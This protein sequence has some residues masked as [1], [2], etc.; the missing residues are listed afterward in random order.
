MLASSGNLRPVEPNLQGSQPI[1][2]WFQKKN[3]QVFD[4][5]KEA[6]QRYLDGFSGLIHAS[7]GTGKTYAIWPAPLIEWM[8]LGDL[9]GMIVSKK[10][11]RGH[12]PLTVLW[13]T[14]LR[15]L[16][17][18]IALS[19]LEPV[20]DLDLPFTVETR[21]GD[22][23]S[24]RR[25]KQRE[26]LPSA[27]VTTP[28]SLSILLSYEN[29]AESFK[30]LKLVVV[31]EWHELIGS[32]R[33]VQVEL[34]L[35]RLRKLAPDLRI[36]GLSATI[37]NLEQALD[38]LLGDHETAKS[39]LVQA[40]INKEVVA[41]SV[42]PTN[43]DNLPWTGH[44]G[45]PMVEEV[46]KLIDGGRTSIVFT[47]VRSQTEQ[48][49]QRI[50]EAREDF[51]GVAALHHGSL[52]ADVRRWV[53]LALKEER[54][55]FVVSTSSLDLGVDFSPVDRVVQIGSPKGVARAMQRAG[56]SGHS[57]GLVSKLYLVPSHALE[58]VEM[59]AARIAMSKGNVECR[60]PLC[61]SIDV[62]CQHVVTIALGTGFEPEDLYE[63]VRSTHAFRNLA[64]EDWSWI[65]NFAATGGAALKAYPEHQRI[66]KEG[67][68]YVISD[69][70]LALKHRL[71][72][73]TI[74]SD[75]SIEVCFTS[76]ER[77]GQVEESF[78]SR[79]K[80]GDR[81]IFAGRYLELV[82]VRGMKARVRIS[83]V[84]SG[85]IPRWMGGR[86]PLSSEL[87][88]EVRLLISK[89]SVG[90]YDDV[91]M[92]FLR[93]LLE[94]QANRS[95]LPE[96]GQILVETYKSRDGYHLF[97]YPF[98]GRLVNEGIAILMAYQ[99][100]RISPSTYS[101]AMN[102]WG[103]EILSDRP[104]LF[105]DQGDEKNP[106][107]ASH[108][109]KNFRYDNLADDIRA[110]LNSTEMAKRQFREIARV[111]GLIFQGYPGANKTVKQVQVSSGLLYDV[112]VDFDPGNLLVRQAH[113]EVLERHLE[114]SRMIGALS[115]L[116][117]SEIVE[118]SL[119]KAS[120]FCLPLMVDRLRGKLTS[121]KLAQRILR[122]QLDLAKDM[123][124]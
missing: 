17:N 22:T 113:D 40:N 12:L 115:R 54:L 65:L 84:K 117:S 79:L 96:L 122:M 42:L 34:A 49:Y 110:C 103:F 38:C 37:G 39:C 73:G 14:P 70:T 56:R 83:P 119:T 57:P 41:Q 95:S 97:V 100:S 8:A 64:R 33:G 18:D 7:T 6:W 118:M 68:L 21:T 108:F 5:Q 77:I 82:E 107:Q 48:W 15:A 53:E 105:G 2:D 104:I 92:T 60:Y 32:K 50:I 85:I 19:L 71:S 123:R 81:F 94:L 101:I 27:L 67:Q 98:E 4:F 25:A 3:W 78:I 87:A 29:S 59:A 16:A 111:A 69:A 63:E 10:D 24:S 45:L 74:V 30:H 44:T 31:D 106:A 86:L 76:G 46:I 23:S 93:P 109:F 47:N 102:D 72:I 89:A 66:R 80:K 36:W 1:V 51:C 112:F 121:E 13:L 52:D 116:A 90:E 88:Y 58:L 120:P 35:A 20:C 55:K 61:N 28:E 124:R 99:L 11:K 26:N 75:Q 91:E 43:L 62:L 114:I 9:T